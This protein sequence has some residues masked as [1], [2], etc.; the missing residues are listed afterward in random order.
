[1]AYTNSQG[2]R[3]KLSV[4]VGSPK[5]ELETVRLAVIQAILESGH[6]PDGM[7]L[8]AAEARPTLKTIAEKLRLCDVHVVIL[9]AQYGQLIESEKV[10]FSE[11]EYRQSERDGRPVIAFLLE[12]D[13]LKKAWE[14]N[15][16]PKDVEE[17]YLV[18]RKDLTAKSVCKL[19]ADPAMPR[20]DRDVLNSINKVIDSGQLRPH[21]GWIRGDSHAAR[22]ASALQGNK[23]LLRIMD[24]V[25]GFNTTSARLRRES[26]AKRA[27]ALMFW[28]TMMNHLARE[29]YKNLF[30]ESGSSLAYVSSI[31]EEKLDRE[32]EWHIATNNAL[33]PPTAPFYRQRRATQSASGTQSARSLRGNIHPRMREGL[34]GTADETQTHV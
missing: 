28:D 31:F 34:R 21:A 24:R 30:F 27:A 7:E 8:W 14:L 32:G 25:V 2:D 6:I 10:G 13:A 9:G 19:Y 18:L 11:W 5:R 20:I 12:E 4:F 29:G 33:S 26:G 17:K 15:P 23:F 1:M 22:L 16:L 3:V